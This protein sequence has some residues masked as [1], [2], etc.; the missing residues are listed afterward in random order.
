MTEILHEEPYINF[1]YLVH[2]SS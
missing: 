1:L 2:Q